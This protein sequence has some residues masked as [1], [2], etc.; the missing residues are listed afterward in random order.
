MKAWDVIIV[1][2]GPAGSALA[3]RLRPHCRVLLLDRD[4]ATL[5]SGLPRIGESLPGAARVL[6]QRIGAFDRFL[7]DTHAERGATVSQWSSHSGDDEPTWFDHLRDPNGPGW[8]L[9]RTRFDASLRETA[10]AAGVELIENC[11]RLRISRSAD[12]WRIDLRSHL[13]GQHPLEEHPLE[14]HAKTHRAPVLVDASGRSAT[15]ARQL[16][17]ARR[18][19]DTL[20]CLYAYLQTDADNEDHCTRLCADR[21]GWWYSVRV[22]SGQRVLAFHLDSD[23]PELKTLRDPERLLA[24]A[25][26]QPLLV[27]A[28]AAHVSAF[29]LASVSVHARPA[30]SAVLDLDAMTTVPPG[31]FAIGDALIAFD[32]IASQGI[33]H[34]LASAESAVRAIEAQLADAPM[35]REP[36]LAEMQAVYARYR[37]HVQATYADVVCYR[38]ETFWARRA[39]AIT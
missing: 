21:N 37:E 17:L 9:D 13:I 36:Y 3:C 12:D 20:V 32:P 34:A 28:L 5:S 25:R 24:K 31:F 6:L 29:A 30:G 18:A 1:G 2:A 7:A 33:F 35:S 38:N 11:G 26:R 14:E 19:E 8:H 15:V 22:P 4:I 10:V 27:D 23:D 16:G 39:V